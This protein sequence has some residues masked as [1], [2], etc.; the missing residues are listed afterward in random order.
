MKKII[1]I[2]SIAL[3]ALI[4]LLGIVRVFVKKT[5]GINGLVFVL[6]LLLLVG[7]LIRYFAFPDRPCP[8]CPKPLPLAVSKH[9]EAFNLSLEN[10]LNAYDKTTTDLVASDSAAI[11]KSANAL[12]LALDSFRVAELQV[13]SLIYQTALQPYENIKAEVASM[14]ADPSLA[15]K[16]ASFNILS[17]ELFALLSTVRYDL[18]KIFWHECSNAFGEGKVG[19]WLSR[20]EKSSSP[21]G[22]KDCVE[23]KTTLNFVPADTTKVQ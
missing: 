12:K 7:G 6:A 19:N 17:N 22:V 20:T 18:A 1:D 16:R 9:S 4:L 23:L 3:P 14:V 13:D 2:L 15:E 11:A 10:V 21:Y 5:R 8:S